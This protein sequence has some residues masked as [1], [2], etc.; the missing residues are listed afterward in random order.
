VNVTTTTPPAL[1]VTPNTNISTSGTQGG[2]FS[3]LS[4]SYTLSVA[5]GSA[6]YSVTNVPNWLTASSTSGFASTS[7]T[8]VTFTVNA[9][10]NTL[11]R[12]TYVNSISFNNTTNGQGNTKRVATLT[13]N[14]RGRR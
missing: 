13:V 9:N 8:T 1:Q 7:P 14:K 6:S 11:T 12:N 5:S 4:F 10:A 2:P 3:P